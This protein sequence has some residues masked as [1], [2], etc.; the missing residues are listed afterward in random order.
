MLLDITPA[1]LEHL[2]KNCKGLPEGMAGFN[3][4]LQQALKREFWRRLKNKTTES[5]KISWQKP[6]IYK[7]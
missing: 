4:L 6:N 2:V 3:F 7:M 5:G 1:A